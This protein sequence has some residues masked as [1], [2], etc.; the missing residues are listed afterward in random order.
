M[1]RIFLIAALLTVIAQGQPTKSTA[2]PATAPGQTL[3]GRGIIKKMY[4]RY[5]GHWYRT[6][7]FDQTTQQYRNDTLNKTQT[8]YEFMRFPDLFRM[9]FGDADSGNA[10]IFRGDTCYRFKNFTLTLTNINNN[11]GLIFLL[12]GMY[13]YPLDRVYSLLDADF[14]LSICKQDRWQNRPVFVIGKDGANQ[15]WIDSENLYVVRILKVHGP[16]TLDGRFDGY[17]RFG[18]GWSETKCSFYLD[19]KLVQLETYHHCKADTPLGASLF[20]PAK[21]VRSH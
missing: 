6:F 7:T 21:L 10:A 2:Q 4:D 15:L 18:G 9:D 17:Q 13:F 12:G 16:S 20:D 1:S 19:G 14:D 5:A 3:S 11:E 8:W